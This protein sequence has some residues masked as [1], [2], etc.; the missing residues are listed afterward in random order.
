M[1]TQI[2][3]WMLTEDS[4]LSGVVPGNKGDHKTIVTSRIIGVRADGANILIQTQSGSE[5]Q[6]DGP[7]RLELI[8]EADTSIT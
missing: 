2:R 3:M 7:S 5:Y 8:R 6:L 1:R 4:R